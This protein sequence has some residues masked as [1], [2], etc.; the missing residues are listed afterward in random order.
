MQQQMTEQFQQS[1][2]MMFRMFTDM[3]QDQMS[4]LREEI[5][6]STS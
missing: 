6:D 5:D 2:L 1:M 3:H 4:L